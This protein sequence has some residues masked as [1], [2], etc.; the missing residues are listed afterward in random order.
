MKMFKKFF[1]KA[2]KSDKKA[3]KKV[4]KVKDQATDQAVDPVMD[5]QHHPEVSEKRVSEAS[6]VATDSAEKVPTPMPAKNNILVRL[7]SSLAKTRQS[8]GGH[9]YQLR[10]SVC[11]L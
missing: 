11:R 7:K 2:K 3:D 1:Q 9:H 5:K 4:G 10:T 8:L 6:S